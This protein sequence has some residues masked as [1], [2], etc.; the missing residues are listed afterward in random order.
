MLV[1]TVP[2]WLPKLSNRLTYS[3]QTYPILIHGIPP[4]FETSHDSPDVAKFLND[5]EDVITHL[6]SL[7]HTEFLTGTHDPSQH[8]LHHSLIAYF[9]DPLVANNCIRR[10]VAF[11]G[12]LLPTVKF[13]C[14]P[15][16]CYNCYRSGHFTCNCKLKLACGLCAGE[17]ATWHCSSTDT[18]GSQLSQK[19]PSK[20]A[21]CGGPHAVTSN[22]CLV[23]R[24][25]INSHWCRILDTGPVYQI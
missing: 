23:R 1:Q 4:D 24:A 13:I 19:A 18:I 3:V 2:S 9:T 21:V 25:A 10:H 15:P 11:Q 17:H 12:H 5:N 20:C 14:R 6:S 16:Q 8:R 22:V 7:Q